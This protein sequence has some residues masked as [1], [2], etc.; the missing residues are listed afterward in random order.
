MTDNNVLVGLV[1]D[2]LVDRANPDEVFDLVRDALAQTDFL[3]GNCECA[4]A[5]N[6]EFAP[7]VT[8]PVAA[9]PSNGP[10]I[11]R[12]GFDV[13]GLANNHAVDAGH[14]GLF[15]MHEHFRAAGILHAGTGA[16]LVEARKPTMSRLGDLT[17]A[18]L[19][20]AS[21]FPRGYE[22]LDDWPGLAPIRAD[23]YYR[24]RLP[25]VWSAGTP[26]VV[27]TIPHEEDME[28]LR[29]DVAAARE[30][31]DIVVVQLHGGDYK[32]PFT[33]SDHEI[34]TARYAVDHGANLISGHHHHMLRGMEWYR[35]API[36]YGLGHFVFDLSDFR[37]PKEIMTDGTLLD[38][39]TDE[40]YDLA[41]RK[42]WPLLPWHR[43][44][45]MTMLAWA[46]AGRDGISSA[47]F[48]PCMLNRAGQ[49]YPVD[50]TSAEG[51]QVTDYVSKGCQT[52]GLKSSFR[53]DEDVRF[54]DLCS[55]RMEK[56]L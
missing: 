17:I 54:G 23:N 52:Q 9:D 11:G 20:Y 51:K 19:A 41:P 12:A 37:G 16:N 3:I 21:F 22:A 45:R 1:G 50:A 4:Y 34:R 53:I 36:F 46:K 24:D 40:S 42:G 35:G 5:S 56:P 31:A 47:G 26:P 18:T 27:T 14:R 28:N 44:G 43:D 55:V 49:V 39:E 38:P 7:G 33:L 32:H 29:S 6:V 30:Q 25:N 13:L 10:A 48:L 8:V 15:E 2:I